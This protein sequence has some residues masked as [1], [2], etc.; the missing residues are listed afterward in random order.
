MFAI[1]F[2]WKYHEVWLGPLINYKVWLCF[3]FCGGGIRTILFKS[4]A[5]L[6]QYAGLGFK[7]S[8][9]F[10]DTMSQNS[11][12]FQ[13]SKS[14]LSKCYVSKIIY[15]V[16]KVPTV[17]FYNLS[18]LCPEIIFFNKNSPLFCRLPGIK[19]VLISEDKWLPKTPGNTK[20][21]LENTK[22][23]TPSDIFSFFCLKLSIWITLELW[24]SF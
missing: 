17:N 10:F 11:N 21:T 14:F 5:S 7:S 23:I 18:K 9:T 20:E 3:W 19:M 6:E 8:N 16:L 15:S 22:E 2:I 4:G 12:I 1:I 24:A 13:K